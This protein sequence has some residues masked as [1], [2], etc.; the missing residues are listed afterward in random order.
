MIRRTLGVSLALA[1]LTQPGTAQ[2]SVGTGVDYLGYSFDA[3]LGTDAVQLF[4]VPVA[5][6]LPLTNALTIDLF[7]AWADRKS[8]V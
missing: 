2:Y 5:V 8:V 4:M 6:R 3:G 1:A 7:S